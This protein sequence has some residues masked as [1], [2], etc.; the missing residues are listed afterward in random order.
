LKE[1]PSD[2]AARDEAFRR[3]LEYER[4]LRKAGGRAEPIG[5]VLMLIGL[6]IAVFG[7]Y[8]PGGSGGILVW[9][10]LGFLFPAL[11]CFLIVLL[12]RRRW[13]RDHPFKG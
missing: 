7:R 10:G 8:L 3:R 12:N 2:R 4:R 1:S 13:R 6:A 5:Y 11:A 9:L